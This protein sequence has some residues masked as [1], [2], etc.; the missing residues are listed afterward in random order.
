MNFPK[1]SGSVNP[2]SQ[3][4][5]SAAKAFNDLT[6][7]K[8]RIVIAL[9]VI[10]GLATLYFVAM[11]VYK[12]WFDP[13]RVD[14]T[15]QGTNS[16]LKADRQMP[17][18]QIDVK[19]LS[20]D[21]LLERSTGIP[22]ESGKEVKV[23]DEQKA[24]N[25]EISQRV[26]VMNEQGKREVLKQ[27]KSS[28]KKFGL[29]V[30]LLTLNSRSTVTAL[31]QFLDSIE[32]PSA[33][34]KEEHLPE[35]L[36]ADIV[37]KG[38]AWDN[39]ESGFIEKIE[40]VTPFKTKIFECHRLLIHTQNIL[41]HGHF[42]DPIP[43][44]LAKALSLVIKRA[45]EGD[46]KKLKEKIGGQEKFRI[47]IQLVIGQFVETKFTASVF[48]PLLPYLR[49][50]PGMVSLGLSDIGTSSPQGGF[51]DVHAEGLLHLIRSQRFLW[52]VSIKTSG[53]TEGKEREFMGELEK[54]LAGRCHPSAQ[55]LI[56]LLSE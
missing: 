37:Q 43:S 23:S 40:S 31:C 2:V 1:I 47:G 36:V 45:A 11:K 55:Q 25:E 42:T 26:A 44:Y 6:P 7:H 51:S 56:N 3:G 39:W 52:Q 13:S 53:M 54:I 33:E 5:D 50:V 24:I 38:I 29:I 19:N 46:I 22:T 8:Q 18:V 21:E 9:S 17:K 32:W 27:V 15:P 10:A 20:L 41:G 35:L 48:A 12:S 4:F 16:T 28:P 49:D 34:L 30:T 14:S